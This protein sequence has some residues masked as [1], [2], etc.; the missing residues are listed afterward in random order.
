MSQSQIYVYCII[1]ST[2]EINENVGGQRIYSIPWHQQAAVVTDV[3]KPAGVNVH[4]KE[5]AFTHEKVVELLM[6]RFT[7]LPMRLLT[8]VADREHVVTLLQEHYA[9]FRDNF[10]RLVQKAEFG[11]KVLWPAEQI[12]ERLSGNC[13]NNAETDI[14]PAKLFMKQK[15]AAYQ[16]EKAF[17][18]EA[19]KYIAVIDKF[20]SGIEVEKKLQT[21][22]TEKLLLNAA[23]L[24]D[25]S[26]HHE[27]KPAFERLRGAL[28]DLE[29]QFS[30]PWPPYNFIIMGNKKTT[31]VDSG[32]SNII[33][34]I[35]KD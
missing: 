30:G 27:V 19:G 31:D 1:K 9:D 24:V 28:S 34:K 20:F 14:S 12:K 18:E 35:L 32:M 2:D 8:L 22:P 33:D 15:Y 17:R 23:Y 3:E 6:D 11:L 25:K 13:N 10:A 7:V 16:A 29:F 4:I 26:K 5:S 21:L